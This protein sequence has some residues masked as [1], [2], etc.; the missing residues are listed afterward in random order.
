MALNYM[1]PLE[2][3]KLDYNTILQQKLYIKYTMYITDPKYT[4]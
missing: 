4:V 3:K 1:F 2:H